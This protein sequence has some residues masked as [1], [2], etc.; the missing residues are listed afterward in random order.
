MACNLEW[1]KG[2]L[3][4]NKEVPLSELN[5]GGGEVG[6]KRTDTRNSSLGVSGTLWVAEST[7]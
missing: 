6:W 7:A 5:H 3:A 4:V 1:L 2:S